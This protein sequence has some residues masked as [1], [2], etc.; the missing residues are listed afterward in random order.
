M[1][2]T[3]GVNFTSNQGNAD[4]NCSETPSYTDQMGQGKKS[5]KNWYYTLPIGK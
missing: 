2:V 5:G 1:A 4:Y 3:R